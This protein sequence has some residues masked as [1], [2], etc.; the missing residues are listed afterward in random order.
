MKYFIKS[1]PVGE[2]QEVIKN[3]QTISG[4][5]YFDKGIMKDALR[6][7]YESHRIQIKLP[8]DRIVMVNEMWRQNPIQPSEENPDQEPEEFVYFDAKHNVKFSFNPIT[9][10]AKDHGDQ[11]DFPE[12]LDQD[13][14]G[15][16]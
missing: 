11:N 8:D 10:E 3:L 16:K 13:W 5:T 2:L 4:A 15:Y 12:Q 7:Y 9:L 14:A 6:E 1:S